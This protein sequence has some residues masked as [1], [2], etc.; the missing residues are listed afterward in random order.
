MLQ[1]SLFGIDSR[2]L[3]SY[4]FPQKLLKKSLK[5]RKLWTLFESQN[6]LLYK[7]HVKNQHSAVYFDF[8]FFS[9]FRPIILNNIF[10]NR[11]GIL[12]ILFA[13]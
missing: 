1:K 10:T 9:N 12:R 13:E 5:M 2:F 8:E 6:I 7:N 4:I 3:Y 11:F